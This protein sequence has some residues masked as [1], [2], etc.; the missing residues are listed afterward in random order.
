[1][2]PDMK[3]KKRKVGERKS[4]K[5][6]VRAAKPTTAPKPSAPQPL[7]FSDSASFGELGLSASLQNAI[8]ES[9]LKKL[10]SLQRKTIPGL[11]T[12][13]DVVAV[14]P[15]ALS[16]IHSFLIPCISTLEKNRFASRN[17]TGIIILTPTRE[18]AIAVSNLASTLLAPGTASVGVLATG[19][20]KSAESDKIEKGINL[21]VATPE[22][23]LEHLKE[24]PVFAT[25]NL[26]GLV[27]YNA[28]GILASKNAV[29][30]VLDIS[31]FLPEERFTAIYT[32]ALTDAVHGISELLTRPQ[33]VLRVEEE[34]AAV[35]A[36]QK[37]PENPLGFVVVEPEDRLLL[38]LT[39]MKKFLDKKVLVLCSSSP[40]VLFYEEAANLLNIPVDIIHAKAPQ[41]GPQTLASFNEAESGI[42]IVSQE[43]VRTQDVKSADWI[44]QLDPP[45]S[46]SSYFAAVA[47]LPTARSVVFLMPKEVGFID[48]CKTAGAQTEEFVFPKRAL[49]K[50]GPIIEKAVKKDFVIHGRVNDDLRFVLYLFL[51]WEV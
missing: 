2:T 1:M 26:K 45:R 47:P 20:N 28:D 21:V 34:G 7:P 14:T 13:R 33:M 32:E 51:G 37:A 4:T 39:F 30:T 27:L 17:G 3:S 11:L 8:A 22:R 50:V 24:M 15:S 46:V 49:M 9:G 44:V 12:G 31:A 18:T 41:A 25:K 38:L 48:D 10:T 29:K 23:L 36:V 43:M 35:E 16:T 6:S 40:A 42:L 19:S 5:P